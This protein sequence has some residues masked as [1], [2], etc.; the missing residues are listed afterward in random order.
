MPR[1]F[2]SAAVALG[3]LLAALSARGGESE[4]WTG[5]YSLAATGEL[6]VENVQGSIWVEGWDRSEVEVRAVLRSPA[7]FAAVEVLVEREADA[8]RF[9]TLHRPQDPDVNPEPGAQVDYHIRAPRQ[10]ELHLRTVTGNI[11]VRDL[12][13]AVEV[14]T[15]AGRV[16]QL[17]LA[18]PVRARVLNGDIRL[19]ARQLPEPPGGIDLETVQGSV[20]LLL[21][22]R[23]DAELRVSTLAGRIESPYLFA[24]SDAA[25]SSSQVRLGRGRTRIRLRTVRGNIEIRER[26]DLL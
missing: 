1:R 19:E 5:T 15:L 6:R 18:G 4:T 17:G 8:L 16:E 9:R 24:T 12:E 10:A 13:G 3:L 2:A 26:G 7:P 11:T 14:R 21:P 25:D 20:A 23:P 22:A